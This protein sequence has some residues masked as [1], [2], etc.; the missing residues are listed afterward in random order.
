[1]HT[2]CGLSVQLPLDQ[3]QKNKATK[4]N[5]NYKNKTKSNNKKITPKARKSLLRNLGYPKLSKIISKYAVTETGQGM[6]AE[7]DVMHD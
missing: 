7:L 6:P 4:T 5:R 3:K 2:P 1:M